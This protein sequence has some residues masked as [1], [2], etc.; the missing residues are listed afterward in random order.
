M[1]GRNEHWI[2]AYWRPAMGW[3]YM[4]IN[5]FDFILAPAFV[6][7]LHMLGVEDAFWK[8]I[9]LENGGLIHVAFGAI[10]GI[11]AWG[12]SKE[13]T[14]EMEIESTNRAATPT[15]PPIKP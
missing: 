7:Y 1:N 12:R 2:K 15:P 10:L 4:A 5:I 9:T 8:S 13:K 3:T 14:T 11:S 6:L